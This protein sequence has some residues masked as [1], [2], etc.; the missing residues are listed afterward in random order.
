MP[1][2]WG[3]FQGSTKGVLKM[4]E[5]YAHTITDEFGNDEIKT[6]KPLITFNFLE[7]RW[8]GATINEIKQLIDTGDL[9]CFYRIKTILKGC[10]KEHTLKL[11]N[12]L[13]FNDRIGCY[14]NVDGVVVLLEDVERIENTKTDFLS[15]QISL[16]DFEKDACHSHPTIHNPHGQSVKELTVECSLD[17]TQQRWL[18]A[19]LKCM[20]KDAKINELQA[21]LNAAMRE[22]KKMAEMDNRLANE[23]IPKLTGHMD[24]IQLLTP[25]INR[26]YPLSQESI[27]FFREISEKYPQI[28]TEE[29][30]Q[31]EEKRKKI[32]ELPTLTQE[33]LSRGWVE[34]KTVA[35]FFKSV[36]GMY[37][38]LFGKLHTT[39]VFLLNIMIAFY[40]EKDS[41][42]RLEEKLKDIEQQ[43]PEG[44]PDET[45][46]ADI[47][48][49]ELKLS[50]VQ[51]QADRLEQ[52]NTDLNEQNNKL[53]TELAVLE[54]QLAISAESKGKRDNSAAII[55]KLRKDLQRWK[56]AFPL[57]VCATEKLLT[58]PAETTKK[59]RSE[60][61][62]FICA[63]CPSK[64][65]K[66]KI[67]CAVFSGEQFE[68]WRD[69]VPPAHVDKTDKA[70][71]EDGLAYL[72]NTVEPVGGEGNIEN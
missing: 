58:H 3:I 23:E 66:P 21:A 37:E 62:P 9:I 13:Y 34:A 30:V 42:V 70:D 64:C 2:C 51:Q 50:E 26:T 45:R 14:D 16:E 1:P 27:D 72:L 20:D 29:I 38:F 63:V 25:A 49:I 22:I 59:T 31:L 32:S 17:D 5:L 46:L 28:S 44:T 12:G 67:S 71:K 41:R 15:P 8:I 40:L 10:V 18:D 57:A 69:A 61:L 36:R 52:E 4:E 19:E 60:L 68:A 7:K 47:S 35:Q 48:D 6:N 39:S 55:G 54:S 24:V 43:K 56:T 53:R 11:C 65:V 33:D